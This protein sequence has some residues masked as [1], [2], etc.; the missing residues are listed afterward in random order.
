[1]PNLM[2]KMPTESLVRNWN[3][4]D[5]NPFM[6]ANEDHLNT[7]N[8]KDSVDVLAALESLGA[9]PQTKDQDNGTT[10]FLF[11]VQQGHLEHCKTILGIVPGQQRLE[12][13]EEAD[14]LDRG[15]LHHAVLRGHLSVTRLL[16]TQ[17]ADVNAPDI[18]GN[19]PLHLCSSELVGTLLLEYGAEVSA[20]NK[21]GL[22]TLQHIERIGLECPE[23]ISLL[24][25]HVRGTD[26]EFSNMMTNG[27]L[28]TLLGCAFIAGV[29]A[30]YM[31]CYEEENLLELQPLDSP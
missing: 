4:V 10:F 28:S 2:S 17:H 3:K 20:K 31:A 27:K 21:A 6:S 19:R 26:G 5:W 1:M 15:P 9:N 14:R 24:E 18:K 7:K 29:I 16:L 25:E 11:W 30:Y 23:L 13:I 8:N 12:L 22:T